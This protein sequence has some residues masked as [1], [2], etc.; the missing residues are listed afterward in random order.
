MIKFKIDILPELKLKGY[1]TSVIRERKLFP[2]SV[3][4]KLR[5]NMVNI[6][7]STVNTICKLLNK[8]PGEIIEYIPD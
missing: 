4:T 8:Q 2:Q 6:D 5:Y 3:L 7:L 1:N